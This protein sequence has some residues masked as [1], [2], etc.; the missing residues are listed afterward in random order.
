MPWTSKQLRVA[1]AV[2]HG[3][4]PKGSAKGFTP[5]FAAQVV[6]EGDGAKPATPRPKRWRRV[7]R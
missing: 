4:R 1:Q 5:K 3:W 6:E 7:K 2:E